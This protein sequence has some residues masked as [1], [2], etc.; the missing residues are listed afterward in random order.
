MNISSSVEIIIHADDY[1]IERDSL[2]IL[3]E[4]NLAGK[5]DSYIKKHEEPSSPVR[6]ELTVRREKN[7][8]SSWKLILS[9]GPKVY[10]SEREH[11]DNLADLVNHLFTHIKDQMAK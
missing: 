7:E 8:K 2:D 1:P 5:M 6:V 10:R 4:K 11:F 9:V 3:V